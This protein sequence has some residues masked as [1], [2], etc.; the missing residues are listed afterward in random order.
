MCDNDCMSKTYKT[1]PLSVRVADAT[2]NGVGCKEFH[3]HR[4][5]I[6]DLPPSPVEQVKMRE[7]TKCHWSYYYNG[8]GLCGCGMCTERDERR[9]ERRKNRHESKQSLRTFMI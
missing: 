4:D 2:D 5:G 1:R 8:H 3:D 9:S 7:Q 6:C